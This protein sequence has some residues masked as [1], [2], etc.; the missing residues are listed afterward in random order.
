M[1]F[2]WCF[3]RY[4]KCR[5]APF[6]GVFSTPYYFPSQFFPVFPK[7]CLFRCY[8]KPVQ[9]SPIAIP[10]CVRALCLTCVNLFCVDR[11]EVQGFSGFVKV[12]F[13]LMSSRTSV[14]LTAADS[15]TFGKSARFETPWKLW[16]PGG[17]GNLR[18]WD[19]GKS[20]RSGEPE[21][22][23]MSVRH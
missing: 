4:C 20:A 23:G 11:G 7:G 3:V 9:I 22:S 6:F 21:L 12:S 14:M 2:R 16:S 18:G 19:V 5:P 15:R 17:F 13:R 1:A 10:L 8:G